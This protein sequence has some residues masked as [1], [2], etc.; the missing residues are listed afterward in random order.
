MMMLLTNQHQIIG[1]HLTTSISSFFSPA[2]AVSEEPLSPPT[3]PLKGNSA[4][5]KMQLKSKTAF[6]VLLSGRKICLISLEEE[7]ESSSP[8]GHLISLQHISNVSLTSSMQDSIMKRTGNEMSSS[9]GV[10][11][12]SPT[13][14]LPFITLSAVIVS[15]FAWSPPLIFLKLCNGD[16]LILAVSV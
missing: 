3:R 5:K 8:E 12:L 13:N 2:M 14:R 11:G 16:V 15:P 10:M 4:G 6:I 7:K 9:C 1:G